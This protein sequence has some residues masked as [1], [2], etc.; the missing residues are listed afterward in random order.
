MLGKKSLLPHQKIKTFPKTRNYATAEWTGA[1][2]N[3]QNWKTPACQMS[4]LWFKTSRELVYYPMSFIYVMFQSWPGSRLQ[5]LPH[6]LRHIR[7]P[8]SSHEIF[9]EP[10]GKEAQPRPI[11]E[12]VVDDDAGDCN[13]IRLL[14]LCTQRCHHWEPPLA[15]DEHGVTVFLYRPVSHVNYFRWII[16]PTVIKMPQFFF[17]MLLFL[18]P[19][20]CRGQ[21]K[22]CKWQ[23]SSSKVFISIFWKC[24]EFESFTTTFQESWLRLSHLWEQVPFFAS[25]EFH[26]KY[27]YNTTHMTT[28]L[29]HLIIFLLSIIISNVT[30]FESGNLEKAVR[31]TDT[32]YE[33]YL[34]CIL[35]AKSNICSVFFHSE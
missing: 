10:T 22:W 3:R 19:E 21:S 6:R 2:K 29:I 18:Q 35:N 30:R 17:L 23:W 26:M 28:N 25:L 5:V 12:D 14:R 33:L 15:G 8:P 4:L 24:I 16:S 31:I 20:P 9:Y 7:S 32:Y 34:R 27:D 1:W 13:A 11:G